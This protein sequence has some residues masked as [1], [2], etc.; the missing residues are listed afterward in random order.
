MLSDSGSVGM[1][2]GEDAAPIAFVLDQNYFEPME[3]SFKIEPDQWYRALIAM[4]SGGVLKGMIWPDDSK[5]D[6]ARFSIA[7]NE[8][9][10]ELYENQSWKALVGFKG[11]ATF[12]ISDYAYYTFTNFAEEN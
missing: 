3:G 9:Q 10:D 4:S 12:T 5:D 11:E 1:T 8:L 2:I 7:A 6:S